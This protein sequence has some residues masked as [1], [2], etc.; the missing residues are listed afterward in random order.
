MNTQ[1]T[2][3]AKLADKTAS[4]N[5][6]DSLRYRFPKFSSTDARVALARAGFGD[7]A[8]QQ[9]FLSR[10]TSKPAA[11]FIAEAVRLL[12]GLG[13]GAEEWATQCA[14]VSKQQ[15]ILEHMEECAKFEALPEEHHQAQMDEASRIAHQVEEEEGE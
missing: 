10:E 7:E 15:A 2:E 3:N 13:D 4:H 1:L 8:F 11:P 9:K 5:L 14:K 12:I 6:I